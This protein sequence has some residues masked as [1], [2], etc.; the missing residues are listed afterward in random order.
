MYNFL[1]LNKDS[2]G[3]FGEIGSALFIPQTEGAVKRMSRLKVSNNL[4]QNEIKILAFI[5]EQQLQKAKGSEEA[6]GSQFCLEFEGWWDGSAE[7]CNL[8]NNVFILTKRYEVDLVTKFSSQLLHQ[9]EI[10]RSIPTIMYQLCSGLDFLHRNKIV[11]LDLKFDNM[12]YDAQNNL[13]I[14]DFGGARYLARGILETR[15]R[16]GTF[17]Y[18]S[19]EMFIRTV[20]NVGLTE[21]YITTKADIFTVGLLLY[22]LLKGKSFFS[23]KTQ[24]QILQYKWGIQNHFVVQG[25]DVSYQEIIEGCLQVQAGGR[26]TAENLLKKFKDMIPSESASGSADT[27]SGPASGSADTAS[28]PASGPAD[29]ASGRRKRRRSPRGSFYHLRF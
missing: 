24:E 7:W 29:T 8:G 17:G 10:K 23:F 27:A 6:E 2:K 11:H 19:P 12:M 20:T 14:I 26:I 21:Q 1:P 15:E 16:I 3:T 28:E 22:Q 5:R 25:I 13:R 18:L 4:I 9:E